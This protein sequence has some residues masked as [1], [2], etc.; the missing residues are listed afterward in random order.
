MDGQR[1]RGETVAIELCRSRYIVQLCFPHPAASPVVNV[2]NTD[3]IFLLRYHYRSSF[4]WS[5]TRS[6]TCDAI[7]R[8][9]VF[10]LLCEKKKT[11]NL[12]RTKKLFF[13]NNFIVTLKLELFVIRRY[14][15]GY[16]NSRRYIYTGVETDILFFINFFFHFLRSF[17]G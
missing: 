11:I 2:T 12:S 3:D 5:N 13:F 10:K 16:I 1:K 9:Y 7:A 8:T 14:I 4:Q 17:K 15:R 6:I